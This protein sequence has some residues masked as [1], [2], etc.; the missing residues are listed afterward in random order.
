MAEEYTPSEESA[1]VKDYLNTFL[2]NST[3][4][5]KKFLNWLQE[6]WQYEIA[7]DS[8]KQEV[9]DKLFTFTDRKGR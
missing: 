5:D 6:R 9:F 3:R 8:S 2:V 4:E 1:D 7:A